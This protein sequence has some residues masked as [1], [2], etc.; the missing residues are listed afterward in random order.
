MYMFYRPFASILDTAP[1]IPTSPCSTMTSFRHNP[2]QGHLIRELVVCLTRPPLEY[3]VLGIGRKVLDRTT[4]LQRYMIISE[5]LIVDSR[6]FLLI[7]LLSQMAHCSDNCS[8]YF[9]ST[10]WCSARFSYLGDTLRP[11]LLFFLVF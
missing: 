2:C 11:S 7:Q 1:N 5:A 3:W 8:T 10:R 4:C 6:L 9:L